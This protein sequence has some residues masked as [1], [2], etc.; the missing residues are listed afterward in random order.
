MLS[1]KICYFNAKMYLS[2]DYSL[3]LLFPL[4]FIFTQA[5]I[6]FALINS[7]EVRLAI[8]S[9][10]LKYFNRILG[11]FV[12]VQRKLAICSACVC[13]CVS[14][15][16]PPL[17]G[18]TMLRVGRRKRAVELS[19]WVICTPQRAPLL[20]ICCCDCCCR[21]CHWWMLTVAF[22]VGT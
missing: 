14:S 22:T 13:V 16:L 1:A 9:S 12:C 15:L 10:P 6:L 4:V 19:P 11:T 5:N 18:A 21:G 2:F 17:R 8:L 20:L 3:S 7:L